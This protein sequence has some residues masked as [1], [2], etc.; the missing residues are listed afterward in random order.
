MAVRVSEAVRGGWRNE[1]P[2]FFEVAVV[3]GEAFGLVP[4]IRHCSG[5]SAIQ[6]ISG[7]KQYLKFPTGSFII[8]PIAAAI[9]KGRKIRS[10]DV[11]KSLS[12]HKLRTR[13]FLWTNLGMGR[14][15]RSI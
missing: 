7:V 5:V 6:A 12:C 1:S 11:W 2:K 8:M 10:K 13:V 3:I 9:F 15:A 4:A 14:R